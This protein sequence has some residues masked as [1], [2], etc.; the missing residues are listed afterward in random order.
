MANS[1]RPN[2]QGG[3][4]TSTPTQSP[5]EQIDLTAVTAP[6]IEAIRELRHSLDTHTVAMQL[7]AERFDAAVPA[8]RPVDPALESGLA[9][10][11][12]TLAIK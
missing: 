4:G 5:V 7:L 12:K 10:L 1:N 8:N 9:Q 3:Y 6:L 2:E 11:R